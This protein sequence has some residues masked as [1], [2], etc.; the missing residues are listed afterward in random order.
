[1]A[2]N[3]DVRGRLN[4]PEGAITMLAAAACGA[5]VDASGAHVAYYSTPEDGLR[6]RSGTPPRQR[7]LRDV[8]ETT[9]SAS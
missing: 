7:Q 9:W 6:G 5:E 4:L 2:R 3:R 8:D 1:M